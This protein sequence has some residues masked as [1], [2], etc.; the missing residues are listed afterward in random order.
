MLA[1]ALLASS[2]GLAS[3]DDIGPGD[4]ERRRECTIER[5]QSGGARCTSCWVNAADGER[6]CDASTEGM[7]MRCAI[8]ATHQTQIWC[9]GP[10]PSSALVSAGG[11]WFW[12]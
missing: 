3:A 10:P 7:T 12:Y 5:Q 9:S 4:E 1:I 8:G 2:A 6:G 11:G